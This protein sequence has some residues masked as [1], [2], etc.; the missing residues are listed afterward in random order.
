MSNGTGTDQSVPDFGGQPL[1]QVPGL[2]PTEIFSLQAL[3]FS[4]AEQVVA[5]LAVPNVA[6]EMKSVVAPSDHAFDELVQKL[7]VVVPM[8][9]AATDT[10]SLPLGALA[11]TEEI[12]AM[13][14]EL[15]EPQMA[16]VELPPG[17]NHAARMSPLKNQGARGTCVAFAMTA[18]HEYFETLSGG[19][20]TDFSEQFLYHETKLIDGRPTA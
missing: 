1:D 16:T 9:A 11:P 20:V 17:V 6:N 13:V 3:G 5:A 15:V 10:E 14:M 2:S 12:D 18:V 7:R 4:D 19:A 8:M